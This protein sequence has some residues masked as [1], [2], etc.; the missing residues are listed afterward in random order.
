MV[1]EAA[2]AAQILAEM[3]E[4]GEDEETMRIIHHNLRLLEEV[5]LRAAQDARAI[6]TE[7][8]VEKCS[9][10]PTRGRDKKPHTWSGNCKM[11][12]FA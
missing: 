4:E 6:Q 11:I 10:V 3:E 2:E 9:G 5:T 8:M 7:C 12:G 1:R